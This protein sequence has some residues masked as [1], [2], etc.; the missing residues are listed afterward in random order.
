MLAYIVIFSNMDQEKENKEDNN[1]S[2]IHTNKTNIAEHDET[3]QNKKSARKV[4]G[5]SFCKKGQ[6]PVDPDKKRVQP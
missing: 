4:Q 1:S 2:E 6:S 5:C 3:R